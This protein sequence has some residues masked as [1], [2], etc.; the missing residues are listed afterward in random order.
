MFDEQQRAIPDLH[1]STGM[2]SM[3]NVF[4]HY[5]GEVLASQICGEPPPAT[6]ELESALSSLRFRQRQQRRGYR[7]NAG[8]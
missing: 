3:G 8:P 1:V 7:L 2:G 5:A 6:R 4:C